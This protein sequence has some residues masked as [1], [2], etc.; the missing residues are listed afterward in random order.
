M[1]YKINI[2]YTTSVTVNLY[3]NIVYLVPNQYILQ[4]KYAGNEIDL[5]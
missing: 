3:I 4:F 2:L 5:E 1:T